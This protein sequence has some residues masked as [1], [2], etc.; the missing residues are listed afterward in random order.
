VPRLRDAGHGAQE[1]PGG[2]Q[3]QPA[4]NHQRLP[5]QRRFFFTIREP[6]LSPEGLS[7]GA[8]APHHQSQALSSRPA[9]GR[10]AGSPHAAQRAFLQASAAQKSQQAGPR[11]SLRPRGGR[12]DV[13][14]TAPLALRPPGARPAARRRGPD[15]HHRTHVTLRLLRVRLLAAA[16]SPKRNAFS[17]RGSPRSAAGWRWGSPPCHAVCRRRTRFSFYRLRR[18]VPLPFD[19]TPP[20]T[21]TRCIPR[22]ADER[23]GYG[24]SYAEA[25]KATRPRQNDGT[26]SCSGGTSVLLSDTTLSW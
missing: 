3:A 14:C 19:A 12:G 5:F 13:A 22:C 9:A 18:A 15:P 17:R 16:S 6:H 25:P 26:A 8:G 21:L 2:R 24:Q 7:R 1:G 23:S 11:S 4:W 20:I 10:K